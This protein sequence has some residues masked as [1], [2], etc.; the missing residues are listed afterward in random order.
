MKGEDDMKE[1]MKELQKLKGIG[2]F[3]SRHLVE[4]IYDTIAKVAIDWM[5]ATI[6]DFPIT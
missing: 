6:T 2:E 1:Q 3:L 4:S 5:K